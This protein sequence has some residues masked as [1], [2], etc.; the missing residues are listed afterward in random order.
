MRCVQNAKHVERVGRV[1][2]SSEDASWGE[3]VADPT[4]SLYKHQILRS[5]QVLLKTTMIFQLN[6]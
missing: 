5:F 6:V 3:G 4:H 1:A 2:E